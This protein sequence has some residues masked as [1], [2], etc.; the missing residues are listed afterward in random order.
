MLAARNHVWILVLASLALTTCLVL[1][2]G[3]SVS[4]DNA[5]NAALFCILGMACGH[6]Y[7]PGTAIWIDR[8]V[9][10]I[11]CLA[12]L[13][14]ATLLGG[15]ASYAAAALGQ[16]YIDDTLVAL[17]AV[18]KLD[19]LAFW[20]FVLA[21][22]RID[23]A[24]HYAYGSIFV[25]PTVML[26]ALAFT[27]KAT[28]AHRFIAAFLISLALTNLIFLFTPSKSA[29]LYFLGSHAP[30][31]P[32]SGA[33]H[34]PIIEA[35]RSGAMQTIPLAD[36]HGL[37]NFPS[38]HTTAAILFIWGAWQVRWLRAIGVIVNGAM[39]IAT[40]IHGGHYF[41][42]LFGGFIV[43]GIA[44]LI[45]RRLKAPAAIVEQQPIQPESHPGIVAT[46]ALLR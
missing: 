28:H 17:D 14:A 33:I 20:N 10:A 44:I 5:W 38:F 46:P 29:A 41:V 22:P 36:M 11:E 21:H 45:A 16:G 12:L 2:A 32:P 7:R 6:F 37:I 19:W 3:L 15:V 26:L 39:L 35:L 24:L 40:P 13:S 18:A 31:L 43:A 27:G 42:D 34:I 1:V 8:L 23:R 4:F 9:A 30:N 25:F